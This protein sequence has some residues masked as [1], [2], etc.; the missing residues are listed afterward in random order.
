MAFICHVAVG[1]GVDVGL[2]GST[3]PRLQLSLPS[4]GSVSWQF[5]GVCAPSPLLCSTA[6]LRL[7][8]DVQQ[9]QHIGALTLASVRYL[10]LDTRHSA[11]R[12]VCGPRQKTGTSLARRQYRP[13]GRGNEVGRAAGLPEREFE[14]VSA[15]VPGG[16]HHDG[17]A[18]HLQHKD[19]DVV[20]THRSPA[21]T[22]F[23][24][25]RYTICGKVTC[26]GP[27]VKWLS[28]EDGK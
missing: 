4:L 26:E 25:I 11:T 15:R 8:P 5:L 16:C 20:E 6:L 28:R 1:S 17:A 9:R 7:T 19:G 23:S 12:Q 22:A 27:E 24:G 2:P 14:D 18:P 21:L 13:A 10:V 3:H